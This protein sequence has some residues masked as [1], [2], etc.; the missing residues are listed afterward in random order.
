VLDSLIEFLTTT[1]TVWGNSKVTILDIILYLILPL[2]IGI[3][4]YLLFVFIIKRFIL[5]PLK[6]KDESKEKI[7]KISRIVL[8]ILFILFFL[9]LLIS[10][11]GP[12]VADFFN[13]IWGIL[14]RPFIDTE[15]TKISIVTI[16]M[17]IPVFYIGTWLSKLTQKFIKESMLSKLAIAEETRFTISIL[18]R[19]GVMILAILIGLSF[20]GIDI[21]SL[22]VLFGVLGI[23]LGFGLQNV[24]ANFF[25]GI[26]LIFE[27]P[28]KEG[29][30]IIVKG[31]EGDVIQIRF[32]STIIN[33]ITNETIIVPNSLLVD[34]SIHNYSY[35]SPRII[36]INQVGVSYKTN[37]NLLKK[38]LQDLDEI[39]PYKASFFN[40]EVRVL[41][42]QNSGI[43]VEFR[44]WI[45][46][47]SERHKAHSWVNL[48]IW[49][50]FKK[51]GIEIPFP[52]MDVHI[53]EEKDF[54][55][56]EL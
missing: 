8:R 31:I 45:N 52:Q 1:I 24:V 26:V 3:V 12:G 40:S 41:E 28:I 33:T 50:L 27:R 15:G 29:D 37:L 30:R 19:N 56:M 2:I 35:S 46:R 23:G 39:N 36:L 51:Y 4:T 14:T 22:A 55:K 38:I 9:I 11:L 44:T 7:L 34:D 53:K 10:F 42:F 6:I 54:L 18:L 32:R 20:L 49:E 5:K 17:V 21:S 43:L 47:A 13:S 48:K 16:I 25:A